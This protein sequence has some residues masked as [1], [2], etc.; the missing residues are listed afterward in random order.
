MQV[1]SA[2]GS[3]GLTARLD[4]RVFIARTARRVINLQEDLREMR[5]RISK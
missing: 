4:M 3:R 5:S 1:T 2:R